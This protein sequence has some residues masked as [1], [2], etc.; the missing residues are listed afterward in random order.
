[1]IG[2]CMASLSLLEFGGQAES[3]KIVVAG[4]AGMLSDGCEFE[5]R[6]PVC[7]QHRGG[8]GSAI[9]AWKRELERFRLGYRSGERARAGG[10]LVRP[11]FEGH[12]N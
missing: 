5:E 9:V 6:L 8:F 11:A 2:G 10:R 1:M 4:L 7:G 3:A 12:P